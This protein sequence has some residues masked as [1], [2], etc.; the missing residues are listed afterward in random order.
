MQAGLFRH[1]GER[2]V[3]II[4]IQ[5]VGRTRRRALEA[6]AAQQ[7]NIQPSVVIVIEKCGAAPYRLQDVSLMI[8]GPANHRGAQ[9]GA[10]C[11]IDKM[12]VK[13]DSRRFAARRRR[14]VAGG[15]ALAERGHSQ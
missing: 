3:A 5:P 14:H 9:T 7:E 4:F 2:A 15:D 6:S 8:L 10:R 13:R 11:D 1:I 12:C